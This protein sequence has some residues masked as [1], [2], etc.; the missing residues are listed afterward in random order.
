MHTMVEKTRMTMMATKR[1]KVMAMR[2]DENKDLEVKI[3]VTACFHN[4]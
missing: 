1:T 3:A 4:S 2:K